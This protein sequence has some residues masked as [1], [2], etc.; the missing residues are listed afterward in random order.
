MERMCLCL[1]AIY[2]G[3]RDF[4][5]HLAVDSVLAVLHTSFKVIICVLKLKSDYKAR[6][7]GLSTSFNAFVFLD[8]FCLLKQT[9]AKS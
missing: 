6:R 9:R 5:T 4:C 1:L 7:F 8:I 3:A 2:V